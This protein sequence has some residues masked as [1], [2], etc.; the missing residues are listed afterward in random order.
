[1]L[2]VAWAT[3]PEASLERERKGVLL[4]GVAAVIHGTK[5]YLGIPLAVGMLTRLAVL[6]LLKPAGV[7]RFFAYFGPVAVL[8]LLYT[9][10]VLFANQ[11]KRIID[12]IG[13]VFRI[14]VPLVLY[15]SIVWTSTFFAF[16][17]FSRS[18]RGSTMGG[19]DKA[20][21]QAF[22]AGSNNASIPVPP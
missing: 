7:R 22:T 16:W 14:C 10:I 2:G 1:M 11:G 17:A 3:L 6:K 12:N 8:G 9:I 13:S 15:F 20:V 18:R 19:Y 4:V 21:T 5:Q